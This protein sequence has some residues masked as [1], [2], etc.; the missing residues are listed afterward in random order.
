VNFDLRA[1]HAYLGWAVFHGGLIDD[2]HPVSG[3]FLNPALDIVN[4]V[5]L[6]LVDARED[7]RCS[8]SYSSRRPSAVSDHSTSATDQRSNGQ[9]R[10]RRPLLG[11]RAIVT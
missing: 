2:L 8:L 7:R 10:R 4:Y 3:S 6:S 5:A 11:G 9:R 1:Y